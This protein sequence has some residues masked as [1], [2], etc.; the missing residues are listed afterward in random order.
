MKKVFWLAFL[1]LACFVLSP[2]AQAE[3]QTPIKI[4]VISPVTGNYGDH[5]LT[6]RNGMEMALKELGGK[7]LGRP[8]ELVVDDDETNPD[9]AARKVRARAERDGIKIYMGGVSS[10]TALAIAPVVQEFGGLYFATNPN[11]DTITSTQAVRNVFRSPPNMS[12]LARAATNYAI[13]NLGKKFFFITHD[14]SWGHSGTQWARDVL[15]KRG[16]TEVGE[17]KVPMG[18]SDFSAQLLQIR[19]SGA[20][21]L[22]ITCA[23]FDNVALL[24]QMAEYK[25]HD[26]IKVVYTLEDF[27]DSYNLGPEVQ[28]GYSATE[29]FWNETPKMEAA[30]K[31]YGELFP[32]APFPVFDCTNYNGYLAIMALNE[33]AEKAGTVDDIPKLIQALEGLELKDNLRNEPS[34]FDARTHQLLSKVVMIEKNPKATGLAMWK[35]IDIIDATKYEM[36]REENPIDLTK[37]PFKK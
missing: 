32:N 6:E 12:S 27:I 14:Y 30:S 8:V 34:V 3:A 7:I 4:G 36:T 26:V 16:G 18:T 2:A 20:E 13:D 22:M 21:V 29:V 35:V 37:E 10:S 23:G 19:N 17:I 5:G 24:K 33:A 31:K 25:I 9:A 11:G 1:A 28:H 15:K